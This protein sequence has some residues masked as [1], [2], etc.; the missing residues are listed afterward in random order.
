M[1]IEIWNKIDNYTKE[2]HTLEELLWYIRDMT[3]EYG[4]IKIYDDDNIIIIEDF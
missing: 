3:L 1:E 4:D 2:V